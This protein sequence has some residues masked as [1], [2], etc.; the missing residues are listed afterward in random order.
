M[1]IKIRNIKPADLPAVLLVE[2]ASFP[3]PWDAQDFRKTLG[4]KNTVG[5][6]AESHSEVVGYV[7]YHIEKGQL[8]IINMAVAPHVRRQKV[9]FI[10]MEKLI[11]GLLKKKLICLMVSDENL[12]GH[13]F[14]R[15]LGFKATKVFRNFFGPG[16][17]GYNFV[18]HAGSPYK[19]NKH[20]KL[21][22]VCQGK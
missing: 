19:F 6:L 21:D 9:G 10:L 16:H 1:N 14:F 12:T 5:L 15:A 13:L 3:I 11:M 7:V 8:H 18:Y 20:K 4:S 17:D 2:N 22:E